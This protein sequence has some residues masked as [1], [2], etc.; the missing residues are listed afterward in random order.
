MYKSMP[1]ATFESSNNS[2][3]WDAWLAGGVVDS[4]GLV[5]MVHRFYMQLVVRQTSISADC[6]TQQQMG[7]SC[8]KYLAFEPPGPQLPIIIIVRKQLAKSSSAT[9]GLEAKESTSGVVEVLQ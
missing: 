4:K 9:I 8:H 6:V 1:A 3:V 5:C 2:I 7:S